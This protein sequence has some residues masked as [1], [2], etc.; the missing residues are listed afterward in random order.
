MKKKILVVDDD[1]EFLK[2]MQVWLSR[3]GYDVVVAV[4]GLSGLTTARKESPD[5]IVLDIGMPAGGGA[6]ALERMKN[7]VPLAGTP[8]VVVTGQNGASITSEFLAMGA[9]AFVSKQDGKDHILVTV[10]EALAAA[11]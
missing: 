1:V 11:A 9:D 2:L 4:D 10:R 6:T 7:L 5:L 3:E 8:I